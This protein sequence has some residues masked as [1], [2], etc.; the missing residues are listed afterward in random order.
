M[1]LGAKYR[2]ELRLEQNQAVAPHL[3]AT[4]Y[5]SEHSPSIGYELPRKT[6]WQLRDNGRCIAGRR[7]KWL[8][9]RDG[10][11]HLSTDPSWAPLPP[12]LRVAAHAGEKTGKHAYSE[13]LACVS[14]IKD[15]LRRVHPAPGTESMAVHAAVEAMWTAFFG[16]VA[17]CMAETIGARATEEILAATLALARERFNAN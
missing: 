10:V 3:I 11:T 4:R 12:I 15:E 7:L 8:E 5:I 9:E 6:A 1:Y 14:I 2:M 16:L 13:L 17:G